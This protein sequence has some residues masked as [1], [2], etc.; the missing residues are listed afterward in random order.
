MTGVDLEQLKHVYFVGI[1]GIGVSAIARM[2]LDQGKKVSGSDK[3]ISSVTEEL[4][5][6]G[7]DIYQ[8]HQAENISAD[9]D[10]VVYS[11][12]VPETNPELVQARKLGILSV[13]YPEVIGEI[14]KHKKTIA[15]SGTHGKTTTT[16]MLSEVALAA[17]LDPMVVVGSILKERNSNFIA[18][19]G[20]H[21]IVEACEYRRSFLNL[22]PEILI[23]TN[24]ETDHLDYYRDLADIQSAFAELAAKVPSHGAVVADLSNPIVVSV[25][26][27][28]KARVVDY[29]QQVLDFDLPQPG[30]HNRANAQAV[31]ATAD[32]LGLSRKQATSALMSFSGTWRRFDYIGQAQSGALVYDDYAHHPSAV[33]VTLA[34]FRDK[35]PDKKLVVI[36]QPHLYSRTK[37]ML[38]DFAQALATADMIALLPIYAAREPFDPEIN[39]EIL[40]D[41]IKR[42][43]DQVRVFAD[44]DLAMES[45]QGMDFGPDSVIVTMG[46]GDV[47]LLAEALVS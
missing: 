15:V 28:V 32:L 23:I 1:G 14:S 36:F 20:D 19:R 6:A 35:Y 24:I 17:D 37:A 10:L 44:S 25:L 41:R 13:S 2:M 43:N 8:D 45:L 46:A 30:Q 12:A 22:E 33:S 4:S 7:A 34:G 3:N 29:S 40:A 18:G 5:R 9:V 16:A 11:I 47:Y 38:D 21:F 42:H 26:S 27:E 39:S 31:L